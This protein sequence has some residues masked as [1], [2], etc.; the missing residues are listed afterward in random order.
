M[1]ALSRQ[2]RFR[3]HVWHV[4]ETGDGPV[5]LLIHGA[6][7]ATQS[8]RGVFPALAEMNRVIAVDLPGQGFTRLGA[9]WRCGL[10]QMAEDLSALCDEIGARPDLIVGH[11]AGAAIALRMALD[12]P[13][14]VVGLNAALGHFKGVAGWLFPVMAKVLA[15]NPFTA[16]MVAATMTEAAVERLLTGTGSKPDAEMRRLYRALASDRAHV[17]GTLTMMS[18]WRCRSV[19]TR[20]QSSGKPLVAHLW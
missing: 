13:V 18:Q 19:A 8:W 9:R 5:I 7:G 10:D 1:A 4:Q 20:W 12:R 15:L 17:D 14:P 16:P 6:G 3:R 2:V 11:S